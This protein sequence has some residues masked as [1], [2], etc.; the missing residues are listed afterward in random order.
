MVNPMVN[1]RQSEL[2]NVRFGTRREQ[3]D[4]VTDV[5][6]EK[7]FNDHIRIARVISAI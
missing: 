2:Q 6:F 4:H 1:S 7:V 3:S 5:R